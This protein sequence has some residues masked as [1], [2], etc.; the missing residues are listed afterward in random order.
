[1]P[2][3]E[4][5]SRQTGQLQAGLQSAMSLLTEVRA[6]QMAQSKTQAASAEKLDGLESRLTEITADLQELTAAVTSVSPSSPGITL[7]LVLLE[8]TVKELE[9]TKKRL[10]RLALTAGAGGLGLGA[11]GAEFLRMLIG[12]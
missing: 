4:S 3:D 7:R 9:E 11:G 10:V 1:M 12:G 5:Q 2:G 8:T 6:E